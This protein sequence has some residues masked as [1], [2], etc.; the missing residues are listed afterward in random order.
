M[1]PQQ[2]KESLH[3][4]ASKHGHTFWKIKNQKAENPFPIGAE[5]LYRASR[6]KPIGSGL[7]ALLILFIQQNQEQHGND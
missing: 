4:Y 7:T 5:N 2:L 6:G 1:T 3:A